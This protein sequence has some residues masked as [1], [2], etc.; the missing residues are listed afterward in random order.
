MCVMHATEPM[1]HAHALAAY[2]RGLEN[3]LAADKQDFFLGV[4]P[5]APACDMPAMQTDVSS[6]AKGVHERHFLHA[7]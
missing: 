1:Q 3:G 5:Q 2:L 4:S 6:V 7:N